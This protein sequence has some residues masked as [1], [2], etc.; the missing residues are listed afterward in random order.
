LNRK[1]YSKTE[2]EAKKKPIGLWMSK[3]PMAPW[4]WRRK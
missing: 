4:N 3:K 1:L 2:R